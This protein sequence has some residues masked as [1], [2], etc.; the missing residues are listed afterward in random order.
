M[1]PRP[2]P[3]VQASSILKQIP[4]AGDLDPV[5][6]HQF[7]DRLGL[8]GGAP[9]QAI[10]PEFGR[11]LLEKIETAVQSAVLSHPVVLCSAM[12]RPHLRRLTE[13]FLPDLAVI[14]HGEVA[15]S[16]KLIS[17]GTIS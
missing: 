16:I 8:L 17:M 7:S 12:V 5:L 13:R 2:L 14:A 9:T 4:R 1:Q 6:E 15:P 11:L 3:S 10:E